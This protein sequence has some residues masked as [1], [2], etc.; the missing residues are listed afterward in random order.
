MACV[1]RNHF[2]LKAMA[3]SKSIFATLFPHHQQLI[4]Q[5]NSPITESA[6]GLS[7]TGAVETEPISY[8]QP[9]TVPISY[10]QPETVPIQPTDEKVNFGYGREF[11]IDNSPNIQPTQTQTSTDAWKPADVKLN[12]SPYDTAL[13]DY[14]DAVLA[15]KPKMPAWKNALLAATH[16][17]N[18]AFN[19]QDQTEFQTAGQIAYQNN[20]Q[21]KYAKFAPLQKLRDQK[22]QEQY[23]QAQSNA[24]TQR[25]IN[26]TRKV[27]ISEFKTKADS[28]YRM[29]RLSLD[30]EKADKLDGYRQEII[31]IGDSKLEQGDKRIG[32]LVEALKD[33]DL[34]RESKEKIATLLNENRI[35]VAKIYA[36]AGITKVGMQQEG[37]N[38][39]AEMSRQTQLEK[40]KADTLKWKAD[41]DVKFANNAQAKA[42]AM[43][44][45]LATWMTAKNQGKLTAEEF[46]LLAGTLK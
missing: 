15:D 18:K 38:K 23:Q 35:D 25:S 37:E 32:I 43:Q 46:E 29:D 11:D 39:R 34:D 40:I 7:T 27:D 44:K 31:R 13:K 6:N 33:K 9:E 24:Q 28:Q 17:I 21:Q 42:A 36:D 16:I 2:N 10:R 4:E 22:L 20:V 1:Q 14:Q 26:D 8:R 5:Q 41:L 45:Q 19:P 30:R 12:L 3:L